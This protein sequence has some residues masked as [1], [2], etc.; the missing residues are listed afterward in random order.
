[1]K[2]QTHRSQLLVPVVV[3]LPDPHFPHGRAQLEVPVFRRPFGRLRG[4]REVRRNA[5][6]PMQRLVYFHPSFLVLP[7][8]VFDQGFEAQPNGFELRT[9]VHV[10]SVFFLPNFL[11]EFAQFHA[12]KLPR[13]VLNT[14]HFEGPDDLHVAVDFF[15]VD[16]SLL[17]ELVRG[18]VLASED[19]ALRN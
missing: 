18:H 8:F 17:L 14:G 1:M 13:P 15:V 7:S 4:H 16:Q 6:I 12:P 9:L 11:H 2:G 5:Q 10:R 3:I 19:L